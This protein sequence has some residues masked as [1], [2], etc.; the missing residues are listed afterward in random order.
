VAKIT[1]FVL[2]AQVNVHREELITDPYFFFDQIKSLSDTY[3][4]NFDG[5]E[6]HKK[7]DNDSGGGNNQPQQ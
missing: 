3:E 4:A 2:R 7:F 5:A 6:L 1:R